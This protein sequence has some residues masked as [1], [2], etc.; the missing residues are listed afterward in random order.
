MTT[1]NEHTEQQ[2]VTKSCYSWND[3]EY[4]CDSLGDLLDNADD[5]QVGDTYYEAD[6]VTLEP[7]AGIH[8]GTVDWLL[9]NMD[10]NIYDSI[11]E[12]YDNECSDVSDE[13]KS[14]LRALIEGWARK[15]INLSRYWK[16]IGKR[17]EMKLTEGDLK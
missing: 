1:P 3:E 5:P 10:E 7:T 9:E 11:G 13:A 6:C 14:E 16:I 12:F 15:H 8:S 4:N 17:R 2:A